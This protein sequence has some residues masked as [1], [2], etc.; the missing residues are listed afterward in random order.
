MDMF[1]RNV[2]MAL[3]SLLKYEQHLAFMSHNMISQCNELMH[4]AIIH[5]LLKKML[6][7]MCQNKKI[8]NMPRMYLR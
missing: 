8:P 1:R 5:V 3:H 2:K 6:Q 4:Y 7:N